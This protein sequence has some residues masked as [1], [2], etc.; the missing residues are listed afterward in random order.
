MTGSILG[1]SYINDYHFKNSQFNVEIINY[2]IKLSQYYLLLKSDHIAIKIK[3]S[4]LPKT[5]FLIKK[6]M[7]MLPINLIILNPVTTLML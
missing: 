5:T 6:E 4:H 3:K 1:L 2:Q 7:M